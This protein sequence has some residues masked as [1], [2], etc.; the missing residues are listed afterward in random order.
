MFAS[1][2]RF[3]LFDDLRIPYAAGEG[4]GGEAHLHHVR[5]ADQVPRLFWPTSDALARGASTPRMYLLADVPIMGRVLPRERVES[6]ARQLGGTWEPTELVLRQ[7]GS[8]ASAILRAGDGSTLLPFDPN[9]LTANLRAERYLGF[10]LR[11]Q[12]EA[13]AVAGRA[14]WYAVRPFMPRRAQLSFRRWLSRF[15]QR[16]QFPRWPSESAAD[17]LNATLL[18]L[19]VEVA[20]TDVPYI[21]PWPE[22]WDW[23]LVLTHDVEG[24]TGYELI[25]RLLEVELQLGFRSSWNFVPC[26]GYVVERRLLDRLGRNGFEIGV[27]GL[28]HDGRDIAPGTFMTRL[29]AIRAY[30]RHWGAVGFRSPG[31]LRSTELLPRLGFD[32]DSSFADTAPF[33]PQPGGCCTWFPFLL[34][35]LVELPITLEQDHT[36]FDLL[37]HRDETLWREKTTAVR[38]RGGMALLLTHP[39]YA[40]NPRLVHSYRRFLAAFADD[41]GAWKALPRDVS[42]WWRRRLASDLVNVEGEWTVV[43]P[44]AA[45]AQIRL[46]SPE[47]VSA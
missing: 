25:D 35:D 32:Y 39:D 22:P 2:T 36:L 46:A 45:E 9:E 20:G 6:L 23:A 5:V 15:Q 28:F 7:D 8:A 34:G 43:G 21:A 12:S 14:A 37:Q 13:L 19:V 31:T 18:R 17:D 40:V 4:S 1:S 41:E 11:G 3:A 42:A 47:R 38:E 27:H 24:R 33:E 29:P 16:R 44:A 26:N 10:G 30:A